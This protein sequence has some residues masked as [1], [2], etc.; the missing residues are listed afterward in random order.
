MREGGR[1]SERGREMEQEKEGEERGV[2]LDRFCTL[3]NNDFSVSVSAVVMRLVP[4]EL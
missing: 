3:S 2:S 1:W 4:S